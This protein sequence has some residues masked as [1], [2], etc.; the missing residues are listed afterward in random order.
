MDSTTR[1]AGESVPNGRV[2]RRRFLA[3]A[4]GA[5]TA[6]ILAACGETPVVPT[7]AP[8]SA[9]VTRM[10]TTSAATPATTGA[11]VPPPTVAPTM[12]AATAVATTAPATAATA[13]PAPTTTA[14]PTTAAAA[15]TAGGNDA[16][17]PSPNPEIGVPE[18]YRR[19]PP[20]FKAVPETPGRGGRTTAFVISYDP[21]APG[22]EN[23]RY[24]QE[25]DKRLGTAFDATIAPSADYEAKFAAV[26][27]G[28]DLP[29]LV[30]FSPP[31]GYERVLLQGAFTD[32]TPYLTGDGLKEYPNLARFPAAV[33]RNSALNKKIY[34][35]PRPRF[36]ATSTF[37]FRQD[38][39]EKVGFATQKNADDVFN[40]FVGMSKMDPDG[41]GRADTFGI[42]SNSPRPTLAM[43]NFAAMFRA[44]N[45][46]RLNP[47][48]TLTHMIETDEYRATLDFARRLWAAGAYH[49]DAANLT[50]NQNKDLFY[51][52][53]I[54]AYDDGLSGLFSSAGARAK[55]RELNP[56]S[57]VSGW[58]PPGHDGGKPSFHRAIGYFGFTAIPARVGR[59]GA[60]RVKEL[61]RLMN[62]FAAPIGSEENTFLAYG[63][64]NV[65]F[66]YKNG[67]PVKNDLGKAEIGTVSGTQGVVLAGLTNPPQVALYDEPGDAEEMQKL[68]ANLLS[69][70]IDNP[71]WG[72]YSPTAAMSNAI[73]AQLRADA[74]ASVIT[75]RSPLASWN[76]TIRDWRSRGGDAI[77]KE[78]EAAI[79]GA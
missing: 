8:T 68:Q 11:M 35:V 31:P 15:M 74:L 52:G 46:W 48:G 79:K 70:G 24:W 13:A 14:R 22:R 60:E 76:D 29:D 42:S 75:G 71:T 47:D 27:A 45:E 49:P 38:W 37:Y 59:M 58:V 61:L 56:T 16:V 54:G 44:P 41:N 25:L 34:G 9:P 10:A 55:T 7:S 19:L 2:R 69:T 67:L 4:G 1:Q 5:A 33:W 78:Y 64:E 32:L 40:M 53:K 30:F 51:A 65:H 72:Y 17:I 26:I 43:T 28:G 36:I 18:A 39:A 73:L 23:N 63:L 20:P 62:Y 12:T 66:T 21:P 50:T 77:R 57:K 3:V 6:A